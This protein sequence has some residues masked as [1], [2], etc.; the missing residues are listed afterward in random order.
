MKLAVCL[1]AMAGFAPSARAAPE[2]VKGH[3]INELLSPG[4]IAARQAML[5]GFGGAAAKTS[6]APKAGV[7]FE[8]PE[9]P[10]EEGLIPQEDFFAGLT[11][12]PQPDDA[13]DP[14]GRPGNPGQAT[15]RN[16]FVNDP[17]LDP[18][19]TAPPPENFRRTVQS[20]TEI[21]V[22]NRV[23]GAEDGDDDGADS[24]GKLMVAGYNDSFGFYNNQQGL[25]GFSYSTDGGKSWI[26]GGGLPPLDPT[27]SDAGDHYFGDPVLVVHHRSRT[28]YYASIYQAADGIFNLSVNRGKFRRAPPQ[29]VESKANTRCAGNPAAFGIPD[30]PPVNSLRIIWEPPVIAAAAI[31]PGDLLDKEWLYVDQRTGELYLVYVR[32]SG[33]GSG[34]TPLELVRSFDGGRTW[35]PPTIIVPNLDDTFNTGL[36]IVTTPSG[37]VI[38]SWTART[39]ALTPPFNEISDRIETAFSDNDGVTFTR[40]IVVTGVNP[41][42]E[43]R[44]Y[45]R[46]RAQILDYTYLAVDKGRFD[47]AAG[48]DEDDAKRPGFGNVYVAYFDGKTPLGTIT[49]AG[50]IKLSTSTT[51][52]AT[53]QRPVKVNDDNTNTSHVFPSVQVN[54]HGTVFVTWVDRRVD[55]AANLLTDT[56]GAFSN[57][58]GRCFGRNIR[59]TD[60][61]TDW[62]ARADARPNFGDYNSSE[63]IDFE[64]FVSIWSDGRF[65]PPV[66]LTVLPGGAVTRPAN[67]A[68]TPDTLVSAVGNGAGDGG[69]R[70]AGDSQNDRR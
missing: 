8:P 49:R 35:T 10:G 14:N 26:D 52:G 39:F 44:G 65:P 5:R 50:D 41:Q 69:D 6:P 17:C 28:F 32:F 47:G 34:A 21:A 68:A 42:G 51:N 70:C 37:R 58:G 48:R 57:N 56:W 11:L 20:E 46:G 60:V 63:V 66:P 64:N 12:F 23:P 2:T 7:P 31:D 22:L 62:V 30:P 27:G 4:G 9:D 54:R 29:G 67:G 1:A 19:P 18:P 13:G 61:S 16:V 33:D 36:S 45:N 53:W 43:P 38:A 55:P 15:G 59:I 40:P 24:S 3:H 25:S